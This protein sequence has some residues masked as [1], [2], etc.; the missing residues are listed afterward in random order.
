MKL[1]IGYLYPQQMNIYG[2]LGNILTLK[3]RCEWRGIEV[4]VDELDLGSKFKAG[5]HDL[6]FFGGGQD[7]E[8]ILASKDLSTKKE[9]L[10]KDLDS[11]SVFLSICGGYQL[12]GNYYQ[13]QDGK[14][15]EGI[16]LID[17]HTVAGPRR[18]IGNLVLEIN[19][20]LGKFSP[21]TLVGFENHSGQTFLGKGVEPLG[22]VISGFGN[23][24]E[25]K[26]EGAWKGTFFGC[27]LHGSL[28]P[29]NPHFADYL[30]ELALKRQDP[31]F[32]LEPLD[33][34]VELQAH[35][36]AVNKFK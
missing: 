1:N 7:Q 25:D 12:L 30:I 8:Q 9:V 11:G 24:G 13:D 20:S 17:T 32:R 31:E 26:T 16:G 21:K 4:I 10:K 34:T 19:S 36:V 2:D 22:K 29:K 27:Y 35:K 5:E 28:L 15:L 14:R 18:M 23:N 33:D 3:K 6:Y